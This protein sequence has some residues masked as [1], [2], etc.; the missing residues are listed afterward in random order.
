MKRYFKQTGDAVRVIVSGNP[1]TR[2][3]AAIEAM[4]HNHEFS[5]RF[6]GKTDRLHFSPTGGPSVSGSVLINMF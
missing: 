2:N 4:M 5:I 6:I 1:I 3:L